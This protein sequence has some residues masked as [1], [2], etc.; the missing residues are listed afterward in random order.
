MMIF[1]KVLFLIYLIMVFLFLIGWF[2]NNSQIDRS[3]YKLSV[4]IAVRNEEK[5]ILRLIKN[6]KSQDY[7][8]NLYDV[9]I[10]DDHSED[11]SWEIL[12]EQA[13]LW[14]NLIV[15]KQHPQLS[16][17]KMRHQYGSL[18]GSL[19]FPRSLNNSNLFLSF[20]L[21]GDFPV[22]EAKGILGKE[23]EESLSELNVTSIYCEADGEIFKENEIESVDNNL[24]WY[25]LY[26]SA[27]EPF[28]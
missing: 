27:D 12:V 10:I 6:L 13:S 11:N 21:N 16:G 9:I 8:N 2:K 5:N 4:V 1:F 26:L 15:L 14:S 3:D 24:T 7:D 28:S 22:N 23:V 25:D 20:S 19:L 18:D 17:K